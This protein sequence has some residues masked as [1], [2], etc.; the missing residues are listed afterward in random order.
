MNLKKRCTYSLESSEDIEKWRAE[1]RRRFPKAA[2]TQKELS[3][4]DQM[5]PANSNECLDKRMSV[6]SGLPTGEDGLR[7]TVE[8][9][10]CKKQCLNDSSKEREAE[11]CSPRKRGPINSC[12]RSEG[13]RRNERGGKKKR[14][15]QR[16]KQRD[17]KDG[18]ADERKD[19]RW[20]S[21][22]TPQSKS[23]GN[24]GS[25]LTT[26]ACASGFMRRPTLFE[27]VRIHCFLLTV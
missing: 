5:E 23:G 6:S 21:N 13:K 16:K 15:N 22:S 2:N 27:K 25:T 9:E 26:K 18:E 3:G 8:G 20:Q 10:E 19:A 12:G 7:E 14:R 1:R 24:C 17:D 4:S 11:S